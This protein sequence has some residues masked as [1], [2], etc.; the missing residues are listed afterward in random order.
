MKVYLSLGSNKEDR[1]SYIK[2]TLD[3]ID[4]QIG[5][6]IQKSS[7]Y[8]TES[9]AYNDSEYLNMCIGIE[10]DHNPEDLILMTQA[11]ERQI[12]RTEKTLVSEQNKPVYKAREIDIDIL[13]C[14]D[15]IIDHDAVKIPHPGIPHRMFIL[16]PL[17]QIAHNFIHPVLKQTIGK[18]LIHC[19][20][21]S[22]VEEYQI[23]VNPS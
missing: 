6:I 2:K 23:P 8:K 7:V 9:W 22:Y 20:D 14:D 18:L 11:I 4:R 1:Y 17:D 12:G 10:C 19:T 13:F 15:L 21:N 16:K 5:K 3:L